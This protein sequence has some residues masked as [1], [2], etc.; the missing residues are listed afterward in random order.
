MKHYLP[1]IFFCFFTFTV[2]AQKKDVTN[3][4][5]VLD[6]NGRIECVTPT[7]LPEVS[8]QQEKLMQQFLQ[9]GSNLVSP[10]A[11]PIKAHIVRRTDG[12]GGLSTTV[13]D[14][15]I[16]TMNTKYATLKMSFYLCGGIHYIDSDAFYA[17][18]VNKENDLL[19]L[20]NV[21]DAVNIYFVGDLVAGTSGLNGISAFPSADPLDNRI[22]MW[23][24]AT[25]N[26]VTLPHEMGHYWNLYHTHETFQGKEF[27]N[28][29]NCSTAGDMVCDTPAD[30]CCYFYN[31]NTCTYTGTAKDPNNQTYNPMVNNLMSYYGLC[32]DIFTAGQYARMDAGY[33]LRLGYTGPNTYTF[34]CNALGAAPTNL[35][36]SQSDCSVTLKWNDNSNVEMG[37]IIESS[38]SASGPW[39]AIGRVP[40][41]TSSYID[42]RILTTGTTY[43]YRIVAANSNATASSS[44][45]ILVNWTTSCYCLPAS[46]SCGESVQ[47]S[48]VVLKQ[49]NTT[50]LENV[51]TCAST[52]GYSYPH[53]I[54]P[55]LPK[56]NTFTISVSTPNNNLTAGAVWI[57]Y[58]HSGTF[59]A[60]E[61][62][63]TKANGSWYT[64]TVNFTVPDDAVSG[65]TRMRVRVSWNANISAECTIA[66]GYGETEDYIVY[67]GCNLDPPTTIGGNRCGT[68]TVNLSASGCAGGTIN[69]YSSTTGASIGI[70]A[71][72]TTPSISSTGTYYA[73]CTLASCTSTR[74]SVIATVNNAAVS[75]SGA[76]RC[77]PGTLVLTA[78]GCAGGTIN[79]YS[80]TTGASIGS[81]ASFTTPSISSTGTY[82]AGCTIASCTSTRTPF[83]ATVIN[84][85]VSGTG[86]SRCGP[87][88]LVL[89]ATGC[90]GGTIN[91]YTAASGGTVA[92]TG[93]SFT[94][95][96]LSD[97][98]TFY[99]GC[100]IGACS[101]TLQSVAATVNTNPGIPNTVGASRCGPG[102]LVL[103]ATG[104]A[105]GT[106]NWY[107]ASTG[108]SVIATGGSYT[109]PSL[110]DSRTYYVGCTVGQCSSS[111]TAVSATVNASPGA[112]VSSGVSRCGA[113]T[114]TL[115]ASGCAGG[116]TIKW[117]SVSSGG[118]TVGTG[119]IYTTPVLST[120]TT[121]YVAC[122]T[123][124]CE[125]IRTPVVAT[126]NV[127]IS[128]GAIAQSAGTYRA[129]ETITS[130]ANVSTGTNYYAGKAIM[131]SPG[132][133]AGSSEVFVAGIQGCP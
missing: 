68:G 108:G 55:N 34:A 110:S 63:L 126:V 45:S 30:P 83:V 13:L 46:Q 39:V 93:A 35:A 27:V 124:N 67:I 8:Q 74:T 76:S 26:G 20:N 21:N 99:V 25:S 31:Q 125:S 59:D 58:D 24:D 18:D 47:V 88:T 78:T 61:R 109:T 131:L 48:N 91:W 50:L 44:A 64:E 23:N 100:T 92:G 14:A 70:G 116:T 60:D 128:F 57:D 101:S 90:A 104:C 127:N 41:N 79:W 111:L 66:N 36:L 7:P 132:F 69:W 65:L 115:N 40:A 2:L 38:T 106:I 87:G 42:G 16:A 133:Q 49:G 43:Y 96:S 102:T 29:T 6:Q 51:S 77:G 119:G 122:A 95:P 114:V 56:N 4:P 113:G 15:A 121:Y 62:I 71:S 86:A 73:G 85:A 19:V 54:V 9:R 84:A 118:T 82:Y 105:G 32:R 33:A 112:P 117:Y 37:Y 130:A 11:I 72:F 94:T 97:S 10:V 17:T 120:S 1:V 129:S 89:T 28:G 123:V 52:T 12:S 75:G 22:I 98:K 53:S 80:S 103:T 3:F 5:V 107:A 81:S